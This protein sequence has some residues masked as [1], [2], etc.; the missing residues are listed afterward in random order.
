MATGELVLRYLTESKSTNCCYVLRRDSRSTW[1]SLVIEQPVFELVLC[2]ATVVPVI[3]VAFDHTMTRN[4]YLERIPSHGTSCNQENSTRVVCSKRICSNFRKRFIPNTH[5]LPSLPLFGPKVWRGCRNLSC[6][7]TVLWM[8]VLTRP[9]DDK[10]KSCTVSQSG[11]PSFEC[12]NPRLWVPSSR[13]P[14]KPALPS[15]ISG[16]LNS[17]SQGRDLSGNIY[18][19]RTEEDWRL[20]D[21]PGIWSKFPANLYNSELVWTCTR[22]RRILYVWAQR[23]C[24]KGVAD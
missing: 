8:L 12:G 16:F 2:P 4:Q 6:F 9:T 5:Q 7:R 18:T 21:I 23:E 20:A 22:C 17:R 24:W 11:N 10:N 19:G 1:T 13:H 14:R 15:R 3:A